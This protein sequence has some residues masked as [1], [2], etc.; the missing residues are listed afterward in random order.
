MAT[1]DTV[2]D[3]LEVARKSKQIDN[4]RLDAFLQT[5]EGQTPSDPRKLAAMF[6][7]DGLMTAFQAEQFLLGK[8]KGFYLGGYRILERL[9]TG[10][11]GTVYLGEHQVLCRRAALK[12]L[13]TP[14][15]EDPIILERFRREAQAAAALDHPN[16]IHVFDFRQEGPLYFIVMEYIE[17]PNLQQVLA[18]HGGAGHR[19][20][21]RIHSPGRRRL[22]A[23]RHEKGLV[24]RDVKPANLLVDPT[25][26][27]KVLDLGLALYQPGGDDAIARQLDSNVI[28]GTADYLSPEQALDL[29]DVDGRANI[30]SLGA[31][32]YTLLAGQPP[33]PRGT[34]AQKLMW[35]QMQ[36]PEPVDR[37]RPEIPAAL[38][39]LVSR[40][41]AKKPEDR[42][43]TMEEVAHLLETWA[44]PVPVAD[45]PPSARS[46]ATLRRVTL[47]GHL[48]NSG[49]R[50][51]PT[52][53]DTVARGSDTK[54]IAA[55]AVEA[56]VQAKSP[57]ENPT[58]LKK[59]GTPRPRFS[60]LR[61]VVASLGAGVLALLR[62]E[63][64]RA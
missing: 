15:A 46:R 48:A 54:P 22:A 13:P 29:H 28:L 44:E 50:V 37:V 61:A 26:T 42:I 20:G 60:A 18:R 45:A 52:V 9:G 35:H 53:D 27:V 7:R 23:C 16:V 43:T 58:P 17:G 49:K 38:A 1:V 41:L 33:F 56:L 36:D 47:T 31:T 24:H 30:Y 64:W 2:D 62:S 8:Y 3:F 10:G 12:V 19:Q 55:S 4:A 57:P 59:A 51:S 32:L 11:T 5:R 14:F 21:L 63:T 34:I 25:G 39:S 6:V 40:M